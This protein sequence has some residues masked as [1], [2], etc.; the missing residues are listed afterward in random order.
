M[1][2]FFNTL[3]EKFTVENINI[4]KN[5]LDENGTT[6]SA[7]MILRSGL[8]ILMVYIGEI[9]QIVSI[10]SISNRDY[11]HHNY[12]SE[13]IC[14]RDT[15]ALHFSHEIKFRD[16]VAFRVIDLSF[17]KEEKT[18]S[19]AEIEKI[20]GYKIKIVGEKNED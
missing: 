6:N 2:E 11:I 9:E 15:T 19:I 14:T 4:F 10:D 3:K 18:M 8:K 7:V 13:K 5:P 12:L 16:S 20:L 1:I 17:P